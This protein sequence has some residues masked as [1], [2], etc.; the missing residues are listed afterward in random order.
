M[1]LLLQVPEQKEAGP[2]MDNHRWRFHSRLCPV[3]NRQ[4]RH[5]QMILLIH[6]SESEGT[7]P[8][9]GLETHNHQWRL[10]R[11]RHLQMILLVRESESKEAYLEKGSQ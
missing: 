8:E 3:T 9:K 5:L 6:E 2:E 11:G 1:I 10:H 4:G 7:D